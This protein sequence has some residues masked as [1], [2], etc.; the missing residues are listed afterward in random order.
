M[1][2]VGSGTRVVDAVPVAPDHA[3]RVP[4]AAF[5]SR[6]MRRAPVPSGPSSPV[7]RPGPM[8]P[9]PGAHPARTGR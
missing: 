5:G 4:L 3:L 2:A 9:G 6:P 1:D 7:P 8:H